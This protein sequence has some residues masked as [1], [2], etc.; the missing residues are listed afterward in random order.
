MKGKPTV[1]TEK[2]IV[3]IMPVTPAR[4]KPK[5]MKSLS[6]NNTVDIDSALDVRGSIIV[7]GTGNHIY[8]GPGMKFNGDLTIQ[9]DNNEVVLSEACIVRGRILIKGKGQRVSV[10]E[11]TTFGSVYMLCQEGCNIDIGHW[12]MFSRDVEIRT[13][14]AHSVINLKNRRRIN[15]PASIIV[16]DHVWVGVGALL[17]KGSE[18]ASDS[19]VGAY[20]FIN[21]SFNESNVIVAG[22]PGKVV[23]QDVTWNRGR[24]SKFTED[25][26]NHWRK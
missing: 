3:D 19:I 26:I 22:T 10:G 5:L 13:T 24:K 4:K 11:K 12:C 15:M 16:G 1:E 9:G 8:F 7:K 6:D 21:D 20:A 14:D 17:S 25:E 18:I 23:K 2:K